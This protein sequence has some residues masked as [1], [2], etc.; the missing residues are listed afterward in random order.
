MKTILTIAIAALSL[1]LTSCATTGRITTDSDPSQDFSGYRTFGWVNS[2]PYS[3]FGAYPVSALLQQQITDSIKRELEGR[4]Y[5]FVSDPASADFAVSYAVGARDKTRVSEVPV[6]DPFYGARAN[7]RWGRGYF[8]A[9]Y[10]AMA[11]ETIVSN[12]TEGTL[13]IDI[14]DVKRRAPVWHG[15]GTKRLSSDELDG[16]TESVTNGVRNILAGFPPQ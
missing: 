1:C 9:Y 7:W 16:S 11:T 3:H 6:A 15:V 13:S 4:G 8:P 12:Y 2:N 14:Y 10:P 5:R